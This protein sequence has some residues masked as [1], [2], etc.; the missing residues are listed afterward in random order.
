M[1]RGELVDVKTFILLSETFYLIKL[2][3]NQL[4]TVLSHFIADT[5]YNMTFGLLYEEP[6]YKNYTV[7]AIVSPIFTRREAQ[8]DRRSTP[9]S[10]PNETTNMSIVPTLYNT[11][12]FS[13]L[14]LSMTGRHLLSLPFK[15]VTKILH[16]FF[17]AKIKLWWVKTQN[18]LVRVRIRALFGFK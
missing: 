15:T 7:I 11:E 1:L 2:K 17:D 12:L 8:N 9:T 10:P 18:D 4:Q 6:I 3:I 13:D 5:K 16:L 14:T